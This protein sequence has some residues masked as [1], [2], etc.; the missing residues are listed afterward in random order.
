MTVDSAGAW[1]ARMEVVA[2]ATRG[3]A[4]EEVHRG[5]IAVADVGG[6]LLGGVGDPETPILLRSA[7]KPFQAL[8]L[9]ATGAADALGI[10]ERELAVVCASHAGEEEHVRVVAG[11]LERLGLSADDLVC[12]THPPFSRVSRAALQASGAAPS[13]LQNNCSGKHA[14]MLGLALF[15]GAPLSGYEDV[16]HPVQGAM[17]ETV[18]RLLGRDGAVMEG[19][20]GCGVPVVLVTALEAATLFARLVEGAEPALR[21][22][23]DAM[24]AYPELVGGE[25]RFDTR[26][27]RLLPG[28][29]VS[30]EGAAGVQGVGLAP[31]VGRL[32]PVGCVL[33]VADGSQAVIP[34]LVGALLHSWGEMGAAEILAGEQASVVRS[35][36]GREVGRMHIAVRDAVLRR[37]E[38]RHVAWEASP[39]PADAVGGDEAPVVTPPGVSVSAAGGRDRAILRFLREEWPAADREIL[40]RTY[41]WKAETVDLVAREG[42]RVVGVL[43]GRLTGGVATI[44]ELLVREDRRGRGIGTLLVRMLERDA[45]LRRCHKVVLRTPAGSNAEWFYRGLGYSREYSLPGHHFGH[46]YV[47]MWKRL[48]RSEPA[49]GASRG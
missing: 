8:T 2:A 18:G 6:R 12:G 48:D 47:G 26:C 13:P 35:L 32:G 41:D 25:G 22:V 45:A 20:D 30:K 43:R 24:M 9:V 23:R 38:S 21:R 29:V 3:G 36:T 40:G 49:R 46:A 1:E 10:T 34:L 11:L 15:L 7:A 42:R 28:D 37:R 5:V 4:L 19:V 31:G 27:M 39:R 17:G 14:G 44:N 33:K 16:A